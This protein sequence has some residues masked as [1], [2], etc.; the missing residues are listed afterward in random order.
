MEA[1]WTS[2]TAIYFH[3]TTRRYIPE[4]CTLQAEKLILPNLR[5]SAMEN[6]IICQTAEKYNEG[7]VVEKHAFP[8]SNDRKSWWSGL[9]S[10][11]VFGRSRVQISAQKPDI[12]TEYFRGFP[13]FP[14]G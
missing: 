6:T 4:T 12:L 9:H 10:C 1:E 3:E 2:E 8:I 13:P 11:F 7:K 5:K 14:P